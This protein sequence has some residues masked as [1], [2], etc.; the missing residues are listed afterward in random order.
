MAKIVF[1]ITDAQV[2]LL[3]DVVSGG[4]IGKHDHRCFVTLRDRALIA[5]DTLH[6]A[7]VTKLGRAA[8]AL[9]ALLP[10]PGKTTTTNGR[11][12]LSNLFF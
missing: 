1:F 6:E 11:S 5:G 8:L 12:W 10:K 2:R 3:R 7:K 9:C 4:Y